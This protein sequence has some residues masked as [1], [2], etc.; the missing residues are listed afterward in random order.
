VRKGGL[1]GAVVES[2]YPENDHAYGLLLEDDIELSP[3]FY[4]YLKLALLLYAYADA[5]AAPSPH[6]E[7]LLGIS[8]Y[9][10][11]LV[12]VRMPRRR[13]DLHSELRGGGAAHLGGSA[14]RE[15]TQPVHLQQLPCSWGSLFF[16][17]PWREFHRYMRRRLHGKAA[18][19]QIPRSA[20]NGWST[21]WKK[22]LIELC[23]LRG[24]VV[25]YPNFYNQTSFST[26]HLE[27]GEH[28]GGKTNTLK[29]RPIDFVVPLM[30]DPDMLRLL[31][32]GA[33]A[34]LRAPP[35][36]SEL[37][38]LDLFSERSSQAALLAQGSAAIS[39][40]SE[41]A[42]AVEGLRSEPQSAQ[43]QFVTNLRL[44]VAGWL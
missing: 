5:D 28:I 13:I 14:P 37:L 22:F 26:N 36:L 35:P 27:P 25:L 31:W 21:S 29:H 39:Q 41:L 18:A 19:V 7:Q 10:P 12:E 40:Q 44:A 33:A 16:P 6:A 38:V 23:Y 17:A 3:Y 24:W 1:I 9:T 34:E 11:R 43:Q 8:L 4:I 42:T 20:T 30:H 15:Y 2:W 32:S